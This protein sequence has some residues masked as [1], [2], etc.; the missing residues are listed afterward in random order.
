LCDSELLRRT[1]ALRPE[2]LAGITGGRVEVRGINPATVEP[3][4]T[5]SVEARNM[6]GSGITRTA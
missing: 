6:L 5:S 2:D 3:G 1:A 4:S